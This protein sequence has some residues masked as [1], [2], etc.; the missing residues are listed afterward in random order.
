MI[1]VVIPCYNSAGTVLRAINS[2]LAQTYADTEIIVVDDGSTDSTANIV[3][4][5]RRSIPGGERKIT[6][7]RQENAGP[8]RARN[9]GM[10]LAKGEYI[11]FLDSD[12]YWLPEKLGLQLAVM[13]QNRLSLLGMVGSNGRRTHDLR[14]VSVASML[15]SNPFVTSSVLVSRS[16]VDAGLFFPEDKK[17]S[18]DY[19]YWLRISSQYPAAVM[20][21]DTI[22]RTRDNQNALSRRLLRMET[23]E[24]DTLA[25]IFQERLLRCGS[26]V[27]LTAVSAACVFSVL[28]FFRRCIMSAFLR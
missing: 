11:A 8:S 4:G 7:E 15:F 14:I 13:A 6:L 18:E 16:V 20:A 3:N 24:L 21:S 9:R 28:K 12:D 25:H 17:Y 22:V 5:L 1:S 10:R 27:S 23:G 2:I 26:V 19:L